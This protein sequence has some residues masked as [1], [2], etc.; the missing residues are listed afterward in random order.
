LI[1]FN[2]LILIYSS[3]LQNSF[4]TQ[5]IFILTSSSIIT[6][7]RSP[8]YNLTD[9]ISKIR[10]VLQYHFFRW[11]IIWLMI[12]FSSALHLLVVNNLFSLLVDDLLTLNLLMITLFAFAVSA[13]RSFLHVNT[14]S[15]CYS[16]LIYLLA[17]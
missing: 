4:F 13:S 7:Y 11:V 16:L 2:I 9:L 8:S 1:T 5:S 12:F 10:P 15:L 6:V 17:L 3:H 14:D